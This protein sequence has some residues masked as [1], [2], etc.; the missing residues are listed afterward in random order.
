MSQTPTTI[1]DLSETHEVGGDLNAL[2]NQYHALVE[3][4]LA[5]R[6]DKLQHYIPPKAGVGF[7]KDLNEILQGLYAACV[8]SNYTSIF[9]EGRNRPAED[10]CQSFLVY[11]PDLMKE[12]WNIPN[13]LN[14]KRM[15]WAKENASSEFVNIVH[16]LN[17]H[18]VSQML[19]IY[20]IRKDCTKAVVMGASGVVGGGVAHH[21]L[22]EN[23]DRKILSVA[24]GV[25]SAA[26]AE[27]LLRKQKYKFDR[28]NPLYPND[29]AELL[30]VM[31]KM[32]QQTEVY[33]RLPQ[34]THKDV[35]KAFNAAQWQR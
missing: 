30:S 11:H 19:E 3:K 6:I 22:K 34:Q 1:V 35:L 31:H 24:A 15:A 16:S 13:D 27:E 33:A 14:K 9:G 10:L 7:P 8:R 17:N 25:T 32:M 20:S 28:L 18:D 4:D 12:K 26:F 5:A 21:T 23:D 29:N 2:T